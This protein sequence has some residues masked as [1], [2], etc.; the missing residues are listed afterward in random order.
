M[1]Y[2]QRPNCGRRAQDG[3]SGFYC[4]GQAG[5]NGAL[6]VAPKKSQKAGLVFNGSIFG[7]HP[8]GKSSNLLFRSIYLWQGEIETAGFQS[9]RGRMPE[10]LKDPT[11]TVGG[12]VMMT[13]N[14]RIARRIKFEKAQ[15][16]VNRL[17][18]I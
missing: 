15:K 7:F 5:C 12:V 4:F 16:K 6:V 9:E 2:T 18:W 1:K 8:T 17:D 3:K 13:G 14:D 11:V 10:W